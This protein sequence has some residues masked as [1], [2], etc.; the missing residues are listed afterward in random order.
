MLVL[1]RFRD[2]AVVIT[3]PE[4]RVIVVTVTA[5]R[6]NGQVRLGFTADDGVEINRDEVESRINRGEGR[7]L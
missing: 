6:G 3:T 7:R 5:V 2:E 1:S 4:G